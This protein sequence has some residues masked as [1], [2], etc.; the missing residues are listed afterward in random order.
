M[1]KCI[2]GLKL[3]G[4]KVTVTRLEGNPT[5]HLCTVALTPT[6][7]SNCIAALLFK[8]N[9]EARPVGAPHANFNPV[10]VVD[11]LYVSEHHRSNA[12]VERV[13]KTDLLETATMSCGR[14][15]LE[16]ETFIGGV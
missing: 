1:L 14:T 5:D 6:T 4:P 13:M 16:F 11:S 12:G 7:S 8:C 15:D 3:N 10:R 9:L 2:G